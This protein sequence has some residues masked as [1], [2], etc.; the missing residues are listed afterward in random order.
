MA[1][2][3]LALAIANFPLQAFESGTVLSML[4]LSEVYG[5]A[6]GGDAAPLQAVAAAVGAARRFAHYSQLLTV[7]SWLFILYALLWRT[8]LVPR[9]LAML[10]MI[11]TLL[12][13]IGVPLR[14]ILGYGIVTEMAMPL[15]P[16]HVALALWL[17]V[18]GLPEDVVPTRVP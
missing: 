17:I 13:I 7:V 6:G 11:A 3:F 16:V 2:A 4:S 18:R 10:G 5:Q 8:A 9:L 15:A 1:L 12:Q 14:G